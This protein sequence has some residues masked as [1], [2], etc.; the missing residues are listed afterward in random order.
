MRSFRGPVDNELPVAAAPG[1]LNWRGP[2]VAVAVPQ[3]LVY[4][5]G[6]E[7]TVLGLSR[8]AWVLDTREML[9]HCPVSARKCVPRADGP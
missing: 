9:D 8:R 6:V 3:L 5:S 7:A 2:G 4:T 1:P